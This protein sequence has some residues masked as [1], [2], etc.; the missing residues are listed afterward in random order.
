[1]KPSIAILILTIAGSLAVRAEIPVGWSTNYVASLSVAAS[2]QQPTLAFFTASWCGPCK[3]M[4]RITLTDPVIAAALSNVNHVAVDIDEHPDLA[5]KHHVTAVP[6]FIMLSTAEDEMDRTTGFQPAGDFL[7]WLTNGISGAKKAV[8][9]QALAK[10]EMAA[11]DRLLDS[12]ETNSL[13]LAAMKLFDLCDFRDPAIIQAAADRL[14]RIANR[15][16]AVLLDGLTDPRLATRIQ[17]ANTLRMKIGDEFDIDPWSDAVS[18]QMKILSW[19][20]ELT[21]R[22]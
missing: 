11:V 12:M 13:H 15:D 20:K 16:P 21:R 4:S 6:T 19:S 18:R 7:Q 14:K 1:M 22:P 2:E 3:L 8:A 10:K 5:T 9:Q 17:I